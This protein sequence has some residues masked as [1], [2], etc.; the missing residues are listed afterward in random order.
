[1]VF[2]TTVDRGDRN[3][4]LTPPSPLP[5][6]AWHGNTATNAHHGEVGVSAHGLANASLSGSAADAA[7]GG[8]LAGAYMSR[9]SGLID[10][11][12]W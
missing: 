11:Q 7:A 12:F 4:R 3:Y 10:W 6:H 9:L 5:C 1:M 8:H 2:P